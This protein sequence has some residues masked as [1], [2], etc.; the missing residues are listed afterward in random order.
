MAG[1]TIEV[2]DKNGN[3]YTGTV[4]DKGNFTGQ[5]ANGNNVIF[6]DVYRDYNGNYITTENAEKGQENYIQITED[7]AWAKDPTYYYTTSKGKKIA[8]S[9]I[10]SELKKGSTGNGVRAL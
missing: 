10:S 5:D 4:D 1:K 7:E 9:E 2:K 3:S 8:V 6:K